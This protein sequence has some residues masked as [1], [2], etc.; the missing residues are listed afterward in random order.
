MFTCTY[1]CHVCRIGS[2]NRSTQ[3]I[4]HLISTHKNIHV[5]AISTCTHVHI[6]V[7]CGGLAVATAALHAF[8]TQYLHTHMYLSVFRMCRTGSRN[9]ST[10]CIPQSRAKGHRGTWPRTCAHVRYQ[11]MNAFDPTIA[12]ANPKH[13]HAHMYR[14]V[15]SSH[16]KSYESLTYNEGDDVDDETLRRLLP[17][18]LN[19][20]V[21][22]VSRPLASSM[23]G[24]C[25]IDWCVCVLAKLGWESALHRSVS[26]CHVCRACGGCLQLTGVCVSWFSVSSVRG[27]ESFTGV[28][29]CHVCGAYGGMLN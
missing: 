24:G 25:S 10:Q 17:P 11:V 3:S 1:I 4:P 27:G 16:T 22:C 2:R 14:S 19:R 8:L 21:L 5:L 6:F 26:P 12:T 28:S 7:V 23:W 13:L 9:R 15:A 29:P 20:C 18:A